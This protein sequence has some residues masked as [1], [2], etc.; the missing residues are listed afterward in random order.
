MS[1]RALSRAGLFLALM[2]LGALGLRQ[3]GALSG[4]GVEAVILWHV[5]LPRVLLAAAVGAML[6]LAGTLLQTV[7]RNPLATPDV[8]GFGG[9]A[10]AATALSIAVTGGLGLVLP[11]AMA[12]ALLSAGLILGLAWRHGSR[13]LALILIGVTVNLMLVALTDVTLSLAPGLQAAEATRFLTGSLA[14]AHW[15]AA[16]AALLALGVA[17]GVAALLAYGLD[18]MDMGD[19]MARAQG[20]RPSRL[21][22]AATVVS[23]LL[24][25]LAVALTGPLPFVALLAGPMAR[26]LTRCSAALP[27]ASAL[28]GACLVLAA[29]LAARQGFAGQSLPAGLYTALVGGP[30]ML[31]LI[32][33]QKERS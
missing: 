11:A 23:A 22:L 17:G 5:R 25:G 2:A 13:P 15:E 28:T 8:I 9:G 31:A 24:T 19:E 1:R 33:A 14:A 7:L 29:D 18:H 6:G 32:L 4:E 12:G 10:S 30:A 21:R 20:L 16:R 27:L 3:G 26:A